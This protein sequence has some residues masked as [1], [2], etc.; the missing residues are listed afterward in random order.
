[1]CSVYPGPCFYYGKDLRWFEVGEGEVMCSREGEDIALARHTFRTEEKTRQASIRVRLVHL[2]EAWQLTVFCV[3]GIVWGLS[4][5]DGTV[6]I[7]KD[8][9]AL[10]LR[11]GVPLCALVTGAEVALMATWGQ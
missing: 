3:Q 4:F 9:C 10:V 5:L 6:V 2:A 11:V 1:M 7:D 8:K